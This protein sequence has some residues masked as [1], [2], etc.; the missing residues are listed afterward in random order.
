[1]TLILELRG[2]SQSQKELSSSSVQAVQLKCLY[3]HYIK[4]F[5]NYC[6][7]LSNLKEVIEIVIKVIY[8]MK[9][10]KKIL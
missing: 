7:K 2:L 8:E 5:I 4:K 3:I 10:K 6:W 1:M 9:F